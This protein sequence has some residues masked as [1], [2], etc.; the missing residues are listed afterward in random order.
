MN[1]TEIDYDDEIYKNIPS[2]SAFMM[3]CCILQLS[4]NIFLISYDNYY[5]L[6]FVVPYIFG[7]FGTVY[8]KVNLIR[9]FQFS[10]I[11]NLLFSLLLLIEN[12]KQ[13]Y[14]IIY[15]FQIFVS[16]IFVMRLNKF[17]KHIEIYNNKKI[18]NNQNHILV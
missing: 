3:L 14:S 8:L 10:I 15:G 5:H 1:N 16:D 9:L 4:Y 12:Y 2:I 18:T 11:I 7:V 6:L 17:I 13:L